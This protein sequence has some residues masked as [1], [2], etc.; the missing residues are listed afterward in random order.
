M[1]LPRNQK[2]G[3]VTDAQLLANLPGFS[4]VS[5]SSSSS[6]VFRAGKKREEGKER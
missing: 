1:F 5:F 4:P 3:A 6:S 2:Q